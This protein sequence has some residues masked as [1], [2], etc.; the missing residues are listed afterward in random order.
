MPIKTRERGGVDS[1]LPVSVPITPSLWKS[2]LLTVSLWRESL[3]ESRKQTIKAKVFGSVAVHA[4]L[5][6]NGRWTLSLVPADVSIA[7]FR[8]EE[9]AMRAGEL[10]QRYCTLVLLESDVRKLRHLLPAWV[11]PWVLRMKAAQRFLEPLPPS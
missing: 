6:D 1:G 3:Q 8:L 4:S 10:L 7:Q 11:E 2:R 5:T 9:D